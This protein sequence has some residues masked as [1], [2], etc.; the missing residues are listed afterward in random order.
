MVHTSVSGTGN[1]AISGSRIPSDNLEQWVVRAAQV[2]LAVWLLA[3]LVQALKAALWFDG[4][5]DNGPFQIFDPLRRI[6]AGQVGGRDFIFFHG[7]GV[8]YLHYP[9][10]ALFGKSLIASELSRQL[11]SIGLFVL[12]LAAF[13]RATMRRPSYRWI[14]A[15][16]AVMFM[17]LLF[18]WSAAPGHS[19]VSAR[20]TMPVFAFAALQ[21][22]IR[23]WTKAML[24]GI[25]AAIGFACGTEHGISLLLA[26][27]LVAGL[28]L[29]QAFFGNR[30]QGRIALLNIRF[31]AIALATAAAAAAL[32]FW[33]L[34]GVDGATK[35]IRYNLVDLPA[36]QFW[37]FGSPP[38][39]YWSHWREL[40][41]DHH[42]VLCLLPYCLALAIFG[43]ILFHSWSRPLR[44]GRDWQALAMLMMIYG[45]LTGIPML[46]ILSRHYAFPLAR[47][48]ALTGLLVFAN[49][50][51]SGVFREWVSTR[52]QRRPIAGLS[53]IAVSAIVALV[54]AFNSAVL[55]TG[56]IRHLRRDTFAYSRF[57]DRHWDSFMADATSLIDSRRQRSTVSL[58][59]VYSAML[60]SHY[61]IFHPAEDYIIH[62]VGQQRWRNYLATFER[63]N[64]E[65]VQ[66]R[67][68]T[69]DFQE[70]LQ[71]ERW[72]FFEAVL[73]NYTPLKVVGHALIWQRT[74]APWR[75]PAAGFQT[76]PIDRV[77][78]SVT[79]PLVSGPDR[80]GVVRI[81]YRV[82]NRW[83][84][85]PLLGKTPRYLAAIEGSPRSLSVSF[86]PY[87][88]EFQFPVQIQSGRTLTLRF[89]TDSLLPGAA[90]DLDEAQVKILDWQA[91]QWTVYGRGGLTH[92]N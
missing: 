80:I 24:T 12:S 89:R 31:T 65:F 72:E 18:P 8:P 20:S 39:P 36:D 11:T 66:T 52:L 49:A 46:G 84:W 51:A 75:Q 10:F 88:P 68:Q 92:A 58:W 26:L 71:N 43:F 79:L 2:F 74:D 35:A 47:I 27:G 64:P 82:S 59:S 19:L 90:L 40:I 41:S 3:Y 7:I 5:P 42:V 85:I 38:L 83:A 44:L 16:L 55:T 78:H 28:P 15:A 70:G 32:I 76:L 48:V 86:P 29:A 57:L 13:V 22:P 1:P 23:D 17:D 87:Q 25:C 21:L 63:T 53:F 60:E 33:L 14:G 9:L 91:S 6:A 77:T 37:F 30:T 45:A 61:G 62:T 50:P 56:L 54:L 67:T 4:V 69:F 81:R 34:C 73:D